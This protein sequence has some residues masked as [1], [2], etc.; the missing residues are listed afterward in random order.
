MQGFEFSADP[1]YIVLIVGAL[2]VHACYQLSVSVLTH[3]SAHT[4]SRKA[5]VRRLGWLGMSYTLGV[6]TVTTLLLLALV[7]LPGF[8]PNLDRTHAME[9]FTAFV[10]GLLPLVGLATVFWYYR[11]GKGTQLWLPRGIASYLLDR[12]KKTKRGFEAF[13]LG[14]GTVFGELPFVVAPLMLVALVIAAQPT[15]SWLGFSIVYAILA[16]VPLLVVTGY[17]TSGHSIARIQRWREDSKTFLQ[18]S[19]GLALLLLTLYLTIL[20]IGANS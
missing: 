16:A 11:R 3:L 9:L 19:S 5:S 14:A 7:N 6:I 18:W 12:S 15:S 13:L 10:I 20:Q 8:A 1:A 4:L 2:F 17:L